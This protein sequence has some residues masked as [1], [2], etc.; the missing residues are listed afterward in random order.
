MEL[1]MIDVSIYVSSYPSTYPHTYLSTHLLLKIGGVLRA[2]TNAGTL[3]SSFP[4]QTW[5]DLP[6]NLLPDRSFPLAES[7]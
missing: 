2:L 7:S 1:K 6:S 5:F 3:N 4:W